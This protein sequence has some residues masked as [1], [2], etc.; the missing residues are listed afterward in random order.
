M[1]P[2]AF[3]MLMDALD[4]SDREQA[5][6][7]Y[8]RIRTI[9]VNFFGWRG[10]QFPEDLADETFN[11]V[12][13]RLEEGEMIRNLPDYAYG[14]ARRLALETLPVQ[15]KREAEEPD[16]ERMP[17]FAPDD[18]TLSEQDVLDK[19]ATAFD[20]ALQGLSP[21]DQRIIMRYYTGDKRAKIEDRIALAGELGVTLNVLRVR[22]YRLRQQLKEKIEVIMKTKKKGLRQ[23][24]GAHQPDTKAV[25]EVAK[26]DP[27][28]PVYDFMDRNGAITRLVIAMDGMENRK[29]KRALQ[30]EVDTI[31]DQR[32]Q[33]VYKLG[34]FS[35]DD[36]VRTIDRAFIMTLLLG[37]YISAEDRDRIGKI[38][39]DVF[40]EE[41]DEALA[42]VQP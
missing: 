17:V 16:W 39:G 10:C 21:D 32:T 41:Y 8:E 29:P 5:G 6:M 2:R 19:R 7:E 38:R 4:G 12:A 28:E 13:R 36:V 37:G 42:Y 25:T 14:V 30:R 11:R 24:L 34:M 23:T 31:F 20:M 3:G 27:A 1:N 15:S 9:L 33:E 26:P 22:I 35:G 18:K 40:R